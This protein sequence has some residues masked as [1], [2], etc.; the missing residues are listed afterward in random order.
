VNNAILS[1]S[2]PQAFGE[3]ASQ[4][5]TF[6]EACSLFQVAMITFISPMFRGFVLFAMVLLILVSGCARLPRTGTTSIKAASL[7]ELRGYLLSHKPDL[8]EFRLRGPFAVDTKSDHAVILSTTEF[9]D[10]D[11]YLSAPDEKAPL[12]IV[13]HGLDNSKADHAYQAMHMASWGMHSLAVQLPNNG[14]WVANGRTV[15]RI[16]DAI[17]RQPEIIDKRVD[18]SKIILVGHSYGGSAMA[19]AMAVGAPAAG[20][21]LLDPAGVGKELPKFLSQI[22]KPVMLLGADEQ[23]SAAR[24]RDYFYTFIR[25]GVAEVSIRDA[26]HED[27]QYPAELPMHLFSSGSPDTEELQITF[28]SALTSAAFSL[29]STG[30]FD[31]AWASFGDAIKNGR[32]FNAKRK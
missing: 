2:A 27:A 26:A 19:I 25:S 10:A 13:L 12:V 32:I 4:S 20:G 7:S 18:A 28:V 3:P 23:R 15:A 31:Y 1:D 17:Y 9:I 22:N 29:W 16:V 6:G 24:D 30:K 14:P 8:D 21:I 11:L 5:A